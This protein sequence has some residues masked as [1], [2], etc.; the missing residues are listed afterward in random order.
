MNNLSDCLETHEGKIYTLDDLVAHLNALRTTS[1]AEGR[2]LRV[3]FTNGCFDLVHRGH[4]TYL[5][6]ARR[7]GDILVV[8]L[9]SDESVRRLKGPSR[10][11][12]NQESRAAVME[13]FY[14]VDYVVIFD[15]DTPLKLIEA[16]A[17]DVLVKGGDYDRSTVVGADFVEQHGGRV[18]LIPLV[19]GESTTNLVERVL[20]TEKD[21]NKRN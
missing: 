10:P 9:N 13:A 17:P 4:V 16:I 21:G 19:P 11:I 20:G 1:R 3:V 6:Q 8:G 18:E 14:F 15:E 2:Q 5:K 12:S 7:L